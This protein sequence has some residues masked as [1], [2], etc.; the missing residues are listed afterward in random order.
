MSLGWEEE[1]IAGGQRVVS[2][3]IAGVLRQQDQ[4]VLFFATASNCGSKG[5]DFFPAKHEQVFSIRAT[6]A[7][8]VHLSLNAALPNSRELVYGTLGKEV[9]EKKHAIP[10]KPKSLELCCKVRH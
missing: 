8:G 7:D 2:N 3:A 4:K 1:Q 10:Y 9:P 6:D 5:H